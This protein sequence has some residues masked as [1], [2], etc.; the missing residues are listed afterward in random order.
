MQIR[1]QSRRCDMQRVREKNTN[2]HP[3]D[4]SI[5]SYGPRACLIWGVCFGMV[6]GWSGCVQRASSKG[7]VDG[8]TCWNFIFFTI[9]TYLMLIHL[10]AFGDLQQWEG[11]CRSELPKDSANGHNCPSQWY[12]SDG[13][14]SRRS[15]YFSIS[16]SGAREPPVSRVRSPPLDR[17]SLRH[18]W[19]LNSQFSLANRR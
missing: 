11:A 16:P 8:R 10:S 13:P 1:V 19:G 9:N 3:G 17:A 2:R 6:V 14:G 5:C 15:L 18:I 4:A 12:Y 7:E